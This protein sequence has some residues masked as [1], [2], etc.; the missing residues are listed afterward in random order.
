MRAYGM[1]FLISAQACGFAF[2]YAVTS[3]RDKSGFALRASP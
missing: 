3:R 1:G 2:G